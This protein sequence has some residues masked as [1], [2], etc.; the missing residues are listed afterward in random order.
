[1][2]LQAILKKDPSSL[3][4]E[5][6]AFLK[7][8]ASEL[9]ESQLKKF[10]IQVDDDS[11]DDDLDDDESDDDD[12][13]D[14]DLD[15]DESDDDD[16]DDDDLDDDEDLPVDKD[17]IK[18]LNA[19]RQ[20]HKKKR[21]EAEKRAELLEKKLLGKKHKKDVPKKEDRLSKERQDFRF[22]H[23]SLKTTTV[24]QI[25]S[26]ARSRGVTMREATKDPIVRLLIKRAK[27]KSALSRASADSNHRSIPTKGKRKDWDSA[28]DADVEAEERR[29]QAAG[30]E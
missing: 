12:S 20:H 30:T 7:K 1:M 13:D 14:D 2:N 5:E 8:H 19:Q 18:R 21:R 10:N 29:R 22:D 16:S 26:Y 28:T 27:K 25:E 4:K 17:T 6:R 23:P 3:S 9:D 15:D 24:D 11:D